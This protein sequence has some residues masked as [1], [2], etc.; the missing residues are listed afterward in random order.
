MIPPDDFI[1]SDEG[2]EGEEVKGRWAGRELRKL[3][4]VKLSHIAVR[5]SRM[6]AITCI[7]TIIYFIY[8]SR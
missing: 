4:W 3:C 1:W 8:C 2:G 5:T 7:M 6:K